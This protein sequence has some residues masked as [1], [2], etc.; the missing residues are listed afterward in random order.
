MKLFIDPGHGGD[1]S[2]AVGPTGLQE[3]EW[4]FQVAELLAKGC[5]WADIQVR[6]SR[7]GDYNVGELASALSANDWEADYYVAIHANAFGPYSHGC[8]VLYEPD[9]VIGA[10]WA[11]Q[12]L[13]EL[14]SRFPQV[15]NRGLKRRNDLTIL[16]RTNMPAI[17]IEPAFISNRF[18][19]SLLRR[20]STKA[21]VADAILA[22]LCLTSSAA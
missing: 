5:E 18:E 20:F 12:V 10:V 14:L 11:Q 16:T 6:W 17:L 8:E 22:S 9:A 21:L 13:D 2:G 15:R 3:K 4:N 19:E 7:N 1:D